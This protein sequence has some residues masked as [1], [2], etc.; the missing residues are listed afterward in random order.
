MWNNLTVGFFPFFFSSPTRTE[1]T[2]WNDCGNREAPA[3]PSAAFSTAHLPA[4][5][6]SGQSAQAFHHE[7]Q[8][9]HEKKK[10][11]LYFKHTHKKSLFSQ[12]SLHSI[13]RQATLLLLSQQSLEQRVRLSCFSCLWLSSC[14]V[15][16]HQ[17]HTSWRWFRNWNKTKLILI[18]CLDQGQLGVQL[19]HYRELEHKALTSL[20]GAT[21]K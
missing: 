19:C 2:E 7:L 4:A 10:R 11:E 21:T 9:A 13:R 5:K 15:S 16:F 18:A 8:I 14:A 3:K 17:L 12:A 1:A 6:A 20:A